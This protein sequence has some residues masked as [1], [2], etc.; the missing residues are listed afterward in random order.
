MPGVSRSGAV[1]SM[2]RARGFTRAAAAELSADVALPVLIG[3]TALKGVRLAQRDG[4]RR[5]AR[6]GRRGRGASTLAAL[7]LDVGARVPAAGWAA[8]RGA[9]GRDRPAVGQNRRR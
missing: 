2:A 7:R 9:P 1:R 8:Y 4:A 5:R 6:G 3:A